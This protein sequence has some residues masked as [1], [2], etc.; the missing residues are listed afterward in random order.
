MV[1]PEG[2]PR[3]ERPGW[4]QQGVVGMTSDSVSQQLVSV[5]VAALGVPLRGNRQDVESDPLVTDAS[6]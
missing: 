2:I 4:P 1:S 3:G 5:I 6:P